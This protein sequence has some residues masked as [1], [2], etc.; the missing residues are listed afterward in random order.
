MYPVKYII[1]GARK[2]V[3]IVTDNM[4]STQNMARKIEEAL[5]DCRVV[6]IQASDFSGSDILPADVCF[7][8]C[9]MPHPSSF[10]Y[11]ENV[12]RHINLAGRS[13]GLF[14]SGPGEAVDYLSGIVRDS[15]LCVKPFLLSGRGEI[16][17]WVEDLI[18]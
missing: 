4:E 7:F 10:K 17:H 9:E 5:P 6:N 2:N 15:E 1:V 13:C 11:L 12:L 8:G 18:H 16:K 3:L 14:S